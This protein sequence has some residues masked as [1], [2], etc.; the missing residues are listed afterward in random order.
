MKIFIKKFIERI[1]TIFLIVLATSSP[2]SALVVN[3]H[4]DPAPLFTVRGSSI[5][6]LGKKSSD[7]KTSSFSFS[8]SPY[9][10]II[11]SCYDATASEQVR[12]GD[13]IGPWGMG[14]IAYNLIANYTSDGDPDDFVPVY[15]SAATF[16]VLW[17]KAKSS[18]PSYRS[19]IAGTRFTKKTDL[20]YWVD[21]DYQKIGLRS[22]ISCEPADG[23]VLSLQGG[24]CDHKASNPIFL[25]PA[26]GSAYP[27]T[28]DA[29]TASPV[30][31]AFMWN[32]ERDVMLS[33]LGLDVKGF[34]EIGLEDITM[35]ASIYNQIAFQ[36]DA[37]S[38]VTLIPRLNLGLTIPA[39]SMWKTTATAGA[40]E[41]V[42]KSLLPRGND[43]FVGFLVEGSACLDFKDTINLTLSGGYT[44]FK[45][46]SRT[47]LRVPNNEYQCVLYP[48]KPPVTHKRGGIW[49]FS[50]TMFSDGFVPNMKCF[51]DYSWIVK[52]LDTITIDDATYLPVFKDGLDV[53]SRLSEF[54]VGIGHLGMVYQVNDNMEAGLGLQVVLHGTNVFKP[55]T[56]MGGLSLCF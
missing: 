47:D 45:S 46:R 28:S 41:S 36:D 48:F 50:A 52:T 29:A 49:H 23:F 21:F 54:R 14:A 11:K 38:G 16:P 51:V 27:E 20:Y 1:K 4:V 9:T 35:Q 39:E 30:T 13:R 8:L 25:S 18:S 6:L 34:Q 22:E 44:F 3:N 42:I 5:S 26:S 15:G 37:D 24:I 2:V 12:L 7:E 32:A 56:F 19:A 55:Y 43:G 40:K 17:A 33:E 10:Q 31:A 53:F